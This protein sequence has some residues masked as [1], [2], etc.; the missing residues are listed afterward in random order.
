MRVRSDSLLVR[1]VAGLGGAAVVALAYAGCGFPD[2]SFIPDDQFD[3]ASV[4]T[5]GTSG[6]GTGGTSGTG[7]VG[8]TS[9][10]AGMSG[11][12]GTA[13]GG[14]GGVGGSAGAS[15]SGGT[16]GAS[17]S[18]GQSGAGGSGGGTGNENCTNGIDDDGDK[19]I[20][21]EDPDCKG[22]GYLCQT[23]PAGWSGPLALY[24]GDYSK[25]P[26]A[27][28]TL[29][30]NA[31]LTA[32]LDPS[33]P[34]GCQC[35]CGG[36]T[37]VTC[38]GPQATLYAAASCG[39]GNAVTLDFSTFNSGD[40]VHFTQPADAGAFTSTSANVTS[41]VTATGGSCS[42]NPVVVTKPDPW[43]LKARGCTPPTPP[44]PGASGCTGSS[45]C[46]APAASAFN[47]G[48]CIYKDGD[49][50]C[51]S[52]SV[53]T[54]KTVVYDNTPSSDTRDC[55]ACQ[56]DA[57]SG[58]CS[59][60]VE[61]WAANGCVGTPDATVTYGGASPQCG[62]F[63]STNDV[64]SHFLTDTTQTTVTCPASPSGGQPTGS[65]TP[66]NPTTFCCL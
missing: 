39:S 56:C 21:C 58:N 55:S 60:K 50:A 44:T 7:G 49:V 4:G 26:P 34:A 15:G 35:T 41:A 23:I 6:S 45:S 18:A 29:Y 31:F 42:P 57:P 62:P 43:K 27:C 13:G 66:A 20:D 9:G 37:G 14:T 28:D 47:K 10:S 19:L 24:T 51:P 36:A 48:T 61:L 65:V 3:D 32:Y 11:T 22:A 59:G 17:G 53:F 33:V 25:S 46:V 40:C 1:V 64:F 63:A 2:H 16:A 38:G 12:G 30:P 52:P 8:G 5:G 54:N